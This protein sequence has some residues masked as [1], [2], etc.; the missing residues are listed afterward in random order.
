MKRSIAMGIAA[1]A[2]ALPGS[3]FANQT[4]SGNGSA[5]F[6]GPIGQGSI[7]MS[8]NGTTI[9]GTLT[10]GPNS[11]NNV[12]VIYVDS[13]PGGFSDTSLFADANDGLRKA[14]SGFDGGTNRSTLT[15][16]SGF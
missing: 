4:I 13:A 1:L 12:L 11:F 6:G 15:F 8:D 5:D 3:V 2:L 14:I 10:K 16:P 7:A 9:S